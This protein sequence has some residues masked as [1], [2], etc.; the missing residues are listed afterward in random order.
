M[1]VAKKS[2]SWRIIFLI[3]QQIFLHNNHS[4]IFTLPSWGAGQQQILQG[5]PGFEVTPLGG[6]LDKL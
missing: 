4:K 6:L 5:G 3:F 2:D 1:R